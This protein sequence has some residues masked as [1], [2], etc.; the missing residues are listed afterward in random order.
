MLI[1]DII[2]IQASPLLALPITQLSKSPQYAPSIS[3]EGSG[4]TI[5][6]SSAFWQRP[7]TVIILTILILFFIA[8]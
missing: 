7:A 1:F 6:L 8:L 3:R 2:V 5:A 4:Q